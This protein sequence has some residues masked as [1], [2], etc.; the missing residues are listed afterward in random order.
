MAINSGINFPGPERYPNWLVPVALSFGLPALALFA[1]LGQ[2]VRG[3]AASL[4]IDAVVVVFVTLWNFRKYVAFWMTMAF[5]AA[6]HLFI[7]YE[8]RGGDLPLPGALFAP[9]F[10]ADFLLWQFV[11]VWAVRVL[12]F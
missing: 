9:L 8:I 10:I 6:F 5:C 4:S 3:F 12:N 2:P 7:P 1:F 11:G